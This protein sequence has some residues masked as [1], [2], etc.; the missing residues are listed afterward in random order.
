[1]IVA[2][3]KDVGSGASLFEFIVGEGAA[4]I[5]KGFAEVTNIL[6]SAVRIGGSDFALHLQECKLLLSLS[7]VG[8]ELRNHCP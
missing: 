1:M 6:Q 8:L 7:C 2:N 3:Q 4:I 5:A